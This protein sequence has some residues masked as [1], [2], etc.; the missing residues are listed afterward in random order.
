MDQNRAERHLVGWSIDEKGIAR[1]L[2]HDE[3]GRNTFSGEFVD[4]FVE[5][6]S[7]IEKSGQAR[8]CIVEGLPDVFCGGADKQSLLDL[9]DGKAVVK[10]LAISERLVNAPFPLMAA[11]EG[12]AVGGGLAVAVCCDI[13]LAARESRY[14]AVFMSMGFTP[15]M[16]ITTLL[17]ELVGPFIA[18]EMMFTGKRFKGRELEG[19]GTNI[20]YILPRTEVAARAYDVAIQIGEKNPKSVALAQIR[21]FCAQTQTSGRRPFAGGHDAP[22]QLWISGNKENRPGPLRALRFGIGG[23]GYG[24][25]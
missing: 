24:K 21:P 16:G 1:I 10:D 4:E 22:H 8:V 2:M 7:E 15:G 3:E 25:N 19:K 11:M 5:A 20:N 23:I 6:I 12:H 17:P 18:N 9:C 13:V 14:G